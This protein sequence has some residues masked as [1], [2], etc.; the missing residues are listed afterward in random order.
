MRSIEG[1]EGKK[2]SPTF[3]WPDFFFTSDDASLT[4]PWEVKLHHYHNHRIPGSEPAAAIRSQSEKK[5]AQSS[6][7]LG[8]FPGLLHGPW[9][10][11]QTWKSTNE[12]N[13]MKQRENLLYSLEPRWYSIQDM[14]HN[15][16]RPFFVYYISI[17]WC[18]MP[19]KKTDMQKNFF[20]LSFVAFSSF[21][22]T[23]AYVLQ[24]LKSAGKLESFSF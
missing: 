16:E 20:L 6:S 24:S 11:D 3:L 23:A 17:S 14:N 15:N 12:I 7:N 10:G 18:F 13:Q 4:G 2:G 9:S 1:G 8:N 19:P 22:R 5:S 21:R